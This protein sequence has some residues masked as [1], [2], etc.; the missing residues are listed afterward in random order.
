MRIGVVGGG[1]WGS[2]HVRVLSSLPAVTQVVLVEPRADRRESLTALNPRLLA[3]GDLTSA[4]PHVDALVIATPPSTHGDLAQRALEAGKHV[5]VE[6]PLTTDV[7]QAR[8]IVEQAHRSDLVLMAGHTFEYNAAVWRL[9]DAI[10]DGDLG[11]VYF[12]DTARLNLG[13]YQPDVNVVWDLAPHDISIINHILGARP[14]VVQA[15]GNSHAHAYL[16]DVAHLRLEYK[17]IEVAAEVRVSWLDPR[18]V[19][20]VTVVGSRKMAVYNDLAE[21]ERIRIYDKAVHT[22]GPPHTGHG[23]GSGNGISYHY[24]GVTSPSFPFEEPLLVEDRHFVGCIQAGATPATDGWNGL[25]VVE[26]LVAA[27]TS[28]RERCPVHLENET[29]PPIGHGLSTTVPSADSQVVA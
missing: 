29:L 8:R 14:D 6:K 1:Y 11:D 5:L 26:V 19:R 18:K 9:R 17:E 10:R 3:F 22:S 21:D 23:T 27:E 4:M 2:K 28:L 25:A 7:N 24:G 12:V 20:R 15:W 13:L 16:E